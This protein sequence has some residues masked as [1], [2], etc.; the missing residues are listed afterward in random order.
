MKYF[1]I[2]AFTATTALAME[3]KLHKSETPSHAPI[4]LRSDLGITLTTT[5]YKHPYAWAAIVY[6][7]N[8]RNYRGNEIL[9]SACKPSIP[10]FLGFTVVT[11]LILKA[12]AHQLMLSYNL[13]HDHEG[14]FLQYHFLNTNRCEKPSIVTQLLSK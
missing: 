5:L 7:F 4:S 13:P 10:R 3:E 8:P 11:G 14:K 2:L 1:L 6:F 9:L 12:T